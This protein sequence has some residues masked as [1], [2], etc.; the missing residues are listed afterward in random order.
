[1]AVSHIG[2]QQIAIRLRNDHDE[3]YESSAQVKARINEPR[4]LGGPASFREPNHRVFVSWATKIG[5]SKSASGNEIGPVPRG[6][7]V[8]SLHQK[9]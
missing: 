3:L 9:T 6:R 5:A 4:P 8:A 2:E 1:M 7:V